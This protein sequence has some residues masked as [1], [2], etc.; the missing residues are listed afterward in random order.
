MF[1]SVILLFHPMYEK[2][3]KPPHSY[4]R[5]VSYRQKELKFYV[6]RYN[7]YIESLFTLKAV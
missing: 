6:S 1:S 2:L 5:Q 4:F 3:S 7:G